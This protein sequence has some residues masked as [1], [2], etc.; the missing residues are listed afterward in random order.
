MVF[1]NRLY[2]Q[3]KIKQTNQKKKK[4]M[5]KNVGISNWLCDSY[6]E[7]WDWLHQILM[8][9]SRLKGLPISWFDRQTF[10]LVILSISVWGSPLSLL[11]VVFYFQH[12]SSRATILLRLTCDRSFLFYS[13][14]VEL[15]S[16]RH[17]FYFYLFMFLVFFFSFFVCACRL[18]P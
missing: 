6:F 18:L 3:N 17:Q 10:V 11:F 14:L 8:Y 13:K 16:E 9:Y 1:A 15:I 2:S 12:S 5:N 7:F 4:R